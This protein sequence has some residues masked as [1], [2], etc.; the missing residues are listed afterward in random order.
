MPVPLSSLDKP[1]FG[2]TRGWDPGAQQQQPRQQPALRGAPR[3]A[4]VGGGAVQSPSAPAVEL[5][6][7]AG[8]ARSAG[9]VGAASR[10]RN[11]PASYSVA[12]VY[13]WRWEEPPRPPP[14]FVRS[15]L[16]QD[17]KEDLARRGA[18]VQARIF[19]IH[20]AETTALCN[21]EWPEHLEM[22]GFYSCRPAA[23]YEKIILKA[24]SRL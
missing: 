23:S 20:P 5:S 14:A 3:N 11:E 10:A 9:G 15:P 16:P 13:T 24:T 7:V 12:P 6:S 2:K 4:A 18:V 8:A 1:F 19:L 22:K 17:A 21:T